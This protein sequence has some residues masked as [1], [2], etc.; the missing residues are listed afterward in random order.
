MSHNIPRRGQ[1]DVGLASGALE[2]QKLYC[3]CIVNVYIL[4]GDIWPMLGLIK[5]L[6][7]V[8]G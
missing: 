5:V 7:R 3:L 4:L 8:R 6:G 1:G 2:D